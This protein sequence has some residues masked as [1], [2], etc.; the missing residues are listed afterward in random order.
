MSPIAVAP[1]VLRSIHS[2][3]YCGFAAAPPFSARQHRTCSLRYGDYAPEKKNPALL[4]QSS[5]RENF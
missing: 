5:R 1:A 2:W 4:V 3:P